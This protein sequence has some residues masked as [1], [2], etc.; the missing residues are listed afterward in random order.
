MKFEFFIGQIIIT[1]PIVFLRPF[2]RAEVPPDTN[3]GEIAMPVFGK[4]ETT[5]RVSK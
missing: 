2:T 5:E 1:H 4:I 3:V